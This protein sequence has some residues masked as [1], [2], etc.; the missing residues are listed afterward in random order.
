MAVITNIDAD[1][2]ETYGHDFERLKRAFVDFAQRCRSTASPCC[3][4]TIRT[5]ARSCRASR[6]RGDLRLAEDARSAPSTSQRRRTDAL[7]RA[8]RERRRI[9]PSSSTCRRAQ[10]AN[11]LAAIAIGREAGVA[12]AAIAKALAEFRG[13]AAASSATASRASTAAD[14]HADRRLRPPSDRD[15]G[16]DRAVRGSFPGRRLV[17][18]FQ[19]HRYTRTRDLFEDFV[20]G[21]VDRRRAQC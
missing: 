20:T 6:S 14:V 9:L 17:L 2:M 1:H 5:C 3:A 18:A 12:D 15:G 19:P 10:R 13:V 21:A 4:S 11:A 7:R 16:D 8:R